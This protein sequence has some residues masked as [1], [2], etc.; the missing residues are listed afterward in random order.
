MTA[1]LS[2]GSFVAGFSS[3]NLGD[4]SPN[5]GGPHCANTGLPC[6]YLNSS[7]PVGGVSVHALVRRRLTAECDQ[8][9]CPADRHVSGV[10]TRTRH[11]R[12]H[13]DHRTQHLPE[14]KGSGAAVEPSAGTRWQRCLTCGA[15]C[16]SCTP[17]PR[18]R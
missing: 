15:A 10:R 14:G 11:V 2:Q 9:L 1:L 5:T 4:V 17:A 3:S 6:D 16:R 12:E 7:C 13:E 18:R 8:L